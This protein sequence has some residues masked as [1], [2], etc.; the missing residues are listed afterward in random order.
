MRGTSSIASGSFAKLP[1]Q[2]P[3]K[4]KRD[5]WRES[6]YPLHDYKTKAVWARSS[7]RLD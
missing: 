1:H 6:E 5:V 2:S 4:P 3:T 7:L